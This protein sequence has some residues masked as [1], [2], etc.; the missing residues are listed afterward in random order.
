MCFANINSE[1]DDPESAESAYLKMDKVV[2][3][4]ARIHVDFSQSVAKDSSSSV[5]T[6]DFGGEG[7]RR[8]R[9]YRNDESRYGK[10]YTYE[11]EKKIE[12]NARGQSLVSP[13]GRRRSRSPPKRRSSR[14]PLR[15]K[16][17]RSPTERRR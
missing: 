3:D 14:S 16:R 13:P 15:R 12:V 8:R 6:Q 5:A 11:F 7:L 9:L 1:F 17:S 4:D 10:T 2:I